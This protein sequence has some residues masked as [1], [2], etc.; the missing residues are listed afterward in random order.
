MFQPNRPTCN[1]WVPLNPAGVLKKQFL[2]SECNQIFYILFALFGFLTSS[3]LIIEDGAL[4]KF[5]LR[6]TSF[7]T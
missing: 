3:L 2:F 1:H 4:E 7:N 5:L 6:A